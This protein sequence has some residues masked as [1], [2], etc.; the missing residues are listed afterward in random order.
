MD[1]WDI[2]RI[3]WRRWNFALPLLLATVSMVLVAAQTVTPDYKATGYLQL[4]PA[5]STGQAN[6]PNAH[7]RPH[8]PWLDL[9]Y[10]ALGNAAQ[11]KVADQAV[12]LDLEKRGFSSS[13]IITLSDRLPVLGIEAVGSSAD[14]AT[15]TVREVIRLLSQDVAAEQAR[16]NVLKEDT[17]TVLVLSDGTSIE[18]VTS[19]LKRV[20]VVAAGVGL[21]CTAA[22]TLGAD[23]LLRRRARRR[24]GLDSGEFQPSSRSPMIQN[25]PGGFT[26]TRHT[27]SRSRVARFPP[28]PC[29]GRPPADMTSGSTASGKLTTPAFALRRS[30]LRR[31]RMTR[32]APSRCQ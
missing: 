14:Q 27:Q 20:L 9:G 15:K 18:V 6:D 10:Q 24:Q 7:P 11:L 12:L 1:L 17:I 3:P 23:A 31:P 16:F 32:P 28:T 22:G 8:N 2:T 21:L 29:R 25:G 4:V 5:P 13:V 19:K 26:A 30:P